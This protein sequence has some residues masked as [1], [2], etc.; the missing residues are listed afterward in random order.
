MVAHRGDVRA[1]AGLALL[2]VDL[3]ASVEI[4]IERAFGVDH[5][6]AAAGQAHDDVGPQPPFVGV[7]RHFGLEIDMLA[8]ARLLEHVLEALLAPAAARLGRSP[9]RIDQVAGLVAHLPLPRTHQLDRLTQAGV[10]V[11]ALLL[12]RLQLLLVGLE[13]QSRPATPPG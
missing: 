11:D 3:V 13:Q 1:E 9:Q 7:D 4:G 2:V 12:D 10:M 5:Q 8:Q 6:I